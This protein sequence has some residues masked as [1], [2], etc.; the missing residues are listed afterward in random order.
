[1]LDESDNVQ[2]LI[3]GRGGVEVSLLTHH[4]YTTSLD[5]IVLTVPEQVVKSTHHIHLVAQIL[6]LYSSKFFVVA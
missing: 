2:D 3:Q 6:N 5:H 1:M 4:A